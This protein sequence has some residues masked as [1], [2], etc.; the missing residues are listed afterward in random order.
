MKI[1]TDFVSNSSS[2]SFVLVGK[3][4]SYDAIIEYIEKNFPDIVDEINRKNIEDGYDTSYETI[5][6]VIDN[7]GIYT[8]I[9]T[10][11]MKFNANLKYEFE[12]DDYETFN[13]C[14][15]INP[16]EMKDNET[17]GEFKAKVN[18]ELDKLNI[19]NSKDVDFVY[20]GSDASGT[21]WFYSCG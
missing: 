13:I 17:L 20:G 8:I 4:Y 9:E 16:K 11:I 10:L 5:E 2:S 21:S 12:A 15:G 18:V 3:I 14:L 7:E 1:R 19:P 6:A